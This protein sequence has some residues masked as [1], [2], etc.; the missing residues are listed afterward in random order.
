MPNRAHAHIYMNELECN[1]AMELH[2]VPSSRTVS[3]KKQRKRGRAFR[4]KRKEEK[5]E[6]RKKKE[7]EKE[8]KAIDSRR[9]KFDICKFISRVLDSSSKVHVGGTWY[10]TYLPDKNNEGEFPESFQCTPFLRIMGDPM[11]IIPI[12]LC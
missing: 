4:G 5:K 8:N 6:K 1:M 12:H 2:T 7:K 10:C 11:G 3:K 9:C